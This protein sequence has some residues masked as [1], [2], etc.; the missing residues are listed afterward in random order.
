M[1]RL[2]VLPLLVLA[3]L[4]VPASAS[5]VNVRVGI[6]DQSPAMFAN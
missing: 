3:L 4:A 1:R 2:S 5:A 6:G